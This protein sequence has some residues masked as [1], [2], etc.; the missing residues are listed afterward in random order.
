VSIA[1]VVSVAA[2]SV[3]ASVFS[4]PPQAVSNTAK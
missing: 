3:V 2:L 4:P 1:A